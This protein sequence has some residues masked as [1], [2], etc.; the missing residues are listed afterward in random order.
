MLRFEEEEEEEEEGAMVKKVSESCMWVWVKESAI[1]LLLGKVVDDFYVLVHD[2][3][4]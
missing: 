2:V 1:V 4:R 3:T